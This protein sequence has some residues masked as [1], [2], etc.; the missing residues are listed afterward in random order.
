M[1]SIMD[2]V[3]GGGADA[4]SQVNNLLSLYS[5]QQG[6]QAQRQLMAQ[7]PDIA[8]RLNM[9]LG[10]V[11]ADIMAGHGPDLIRNLEPTD[12]MK[13]YQQGVAMLVSQG[14]TL[15]DAKA[16]MEPLLY[17]A[18]V[19]PALADFRQ[20]YLQAKRDGTLAQHPE[21]TSGFENWKAQLS[22]KA[23]DRTTKQNMVN[24]ALGE[25]PGLER[26][27]SGIHDKIASLT[28]A[29]NDG[30]LDNLFN[31]PSGLTG[32]LANNPTWNA[33][34]G[35]LTQNKVQLSDEDRNNLKNIVELSQTS[36]HAFAATSTRQIA[37][38]LGSISASIS[39][40]GDLSRGKK[41]WFEKLS[42]LDNNVQNTRADNFGEANLTPPDRD[43][44]QRMNPLYA[45]GGAFNL[46]TPQPLPPDAVKSV[47]SAPP[48]DVP[49]LLKD[50][51]AQNY[52]TKEVRR[53]LQQRG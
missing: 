37:P 53:Q 26:T 8:Q 15:D 50:L 24:I 18:N 7:A 51:E 34:A 45:A 21:L 23:Q 6:L 13:N 14:M 44:R 4:G 28:A 2:S 9:P 16:A 12:T 19:D 42:E 20:Q 46:R 1:R 36:P 25:Q 10:V 41:G 49:G 47:L 22:A 5:A 40:V 29:Y 27:L 11:Q 48:E 38:T 3:N 17:G 32:F 33:V 35:F 31:Q 39:S 43:L 30:K 52:D